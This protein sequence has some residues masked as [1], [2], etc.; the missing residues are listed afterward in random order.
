[1]RPC[2][3]MLQH[4]VIVVDDI[5]PTRQCVT[6][7]TTMTSAICSPTWCIYMI[8]AMLSCYL[9]IMKTGIHSRRELLSKV[10]EAI[11]CESTQVDYLQTG[12]DP[13]KDDR[14]ADEILWG[15]LCSN[16]LVM[17]SNCFNSCP[18]G[19]SPMMLDG[20]VWGQCCQSVRSVSEVQLDVLP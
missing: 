3:M 5:T 8:S 20:E 2:I 4:D 19:W 1:M 16:S 6:Q 9:S 10:P 7:S 18:I 13:T 11:K 15:S 17:Q 12:W 14:Y